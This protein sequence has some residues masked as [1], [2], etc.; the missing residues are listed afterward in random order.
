MSP[1]SVPQ[2]TREIPHKGSRKHALSGPRSPGDSR[3]APAHSITALPLSSPRAADLHEGGAEVAGDLVTRP[4][5]VA[6]LHPAGHRSLRGGGLGARQG[7]RSHDQHQQQHG[8][9][10]YEP[11]E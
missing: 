10:C 8:F 4:R 9:K 2:T 7:G 6:G 3:P 1:L 11:R 5:D